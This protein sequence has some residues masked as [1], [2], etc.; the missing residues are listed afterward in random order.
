MRYLKTFES[1]GEESIILDLKDMALELNDSGFNIAVYNDPIGDTGNILVKIVHSK[2]FTMG[3]LVKEFIF[4][5]TDYMKENGYEF[6]SHSNFGRLHLVE[7][8]RIILTS[9]EA[10]ERYP[11]FTMINITFKKN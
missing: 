11:S 4:R 7:D 5:I 1:L 3:P 2:N 8:G 9:G 10:R 6:D